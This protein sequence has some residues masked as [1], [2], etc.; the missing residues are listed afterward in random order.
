MNER[1]YRASAVYQ[2]PIPAGQVMYAMSSRSVGQQQPLYRRHAM[3]KHCISC[4]RVS[5]YMSVRLL[6]PGIV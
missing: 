3:R 5:F 1:I 6:R 2:S 4:R